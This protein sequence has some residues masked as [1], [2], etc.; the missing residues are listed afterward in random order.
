MATAP[1]RQRSTGIT[2]SPSA[3]SEARVGRRP[4]RLQFDASRHMSAMG[5]ALPSRVLEGPPMSN[6]WRTAWQG[7]DI[8]IYRDET[9]VDRVTAG[10]IERVVFVYTGT[11]ES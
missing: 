8:V 9:E 6:T 7:Q 1:S 3:C 5:D 11:G 2:A 10:D 4:A